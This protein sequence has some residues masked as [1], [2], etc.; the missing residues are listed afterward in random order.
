MEI[1]AQHV[2]ELR[3]RTGAGMMEC[4]KALTEAKGDM[5]EAITILR[6]RGLASAAKKS[7]RITSEGLVDIQ[8]SPVNGKSVG[9][10]VELNCETDFVART[11]EFKALVTQM[12]SHILVQKPSSVEEMLSQRLG[13]GDAKTIRE[14]LTDRIARVGENLSLRRFERY[15]LDGTG[16]LGKYIHAGGKIG[17][18]VELGVADVE[19][20]REELQHL[21]HDV[22]MHVAASDPRFLGR[23]DVP[24]DVLEKEKEIARAKVPAGKPPQVIE[25]IVEGQLTKFYGEVCLLEQ[26]FVKEPGVTVGQWVSQK[27]S[28]LGGTVE[29]RR[30]VRFKTGEGLE[31]RGDDFAA[32]V[33]AQLK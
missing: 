28:A 8:I 21:V 16:V 1:S 29:V 26:P 17:V 13:S 24:A 33:A 10:I 15:E 4:K 20:Q 18:L 5:E 19:T 22:A 25:R 23:N 7:G 6:K 31:K 9:A 14:E 3:E 12:A 30:Y 11:E 2:K 27:G 32:E